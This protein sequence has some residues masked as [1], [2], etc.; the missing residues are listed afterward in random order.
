MWKNFPPPLVTLPN[1][2]SS[3]LSGHSDHIVLEPFD[4]TLWYSGVPWLPNLLK[5]S[6]DIKSIEI[7]KMAFSAHCTQI[8]KLNRISMTIISKVAWKCIWCSHQVQRCMTAPHS[9]RKLC[10]GTLKHGQGST[11]AYSPY[12]WQT[13]GG[14][15]SLGTPITNLFNSNKIMR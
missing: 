6:L 3:C 2:V 12:G 10:S 14:T 5:I 8:W 1:W 7:M 13:F 9:G 11:S 15:C 4:V